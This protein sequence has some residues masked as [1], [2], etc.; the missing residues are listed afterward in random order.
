MAW[1]LEDILDGNVGFFWPQ[2]NYK[3]DISSEPERG[4]IERKDRI[5]E[6]RTLE[7]DPLS[8]FFDM[9]K[10]EKMRKPHAVV[11]STEKTG[12]VLA[13]VTGIGSNLV[14]GAAASVNRFRGQILVCGVDVTTLKSVRFNEIEVFFPGVNRWFGVQPPK[15]SRKIDKR[16][17]LTQMSI[18]LR[19]DK[20]AIIP[21]TDSS[22]LTIYNYWSLN[23]PADS[24]MIFAPVSIGVRSRKRL[25]LIDLLAPIFQTQNLLNVAYR[26]FVSANGGRV[27]PHAMGEHAT[28]YRLWASPV[29]TKPPHASQATSLT[30]VPLF[31]LSQLGGNEA[32]SKWIQLCNDLPRLAGP[33]ANI[34][35]AGTSTIEAQLLT[36]GATIDYW[37]GSNK[38]VKSWAKSENFQPKAVINSLPPGFDYLVGDIDKWAERFWGY[39]NAI[40]HNVSK[41]NIDLAE[42]YVLAQSAHVLVTLLALNEI[43]TRPQVIK[44]ICE[45]HR[46][47]SLRDQIA[48]H[49][50]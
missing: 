23:G 43:S 13:N 48:T 31:S 11:G 8:E 46:L 44:E 36:S 27:R 28:Y 40:K 50:K 39:Y 14:V 41:F 22:K 15:V 24:Q 6:I 30:E 21:L 19:S 7:E 34:Y 4:Y 1:E 17:R 25:E 3:V 5:V 26:G 29:M 32:L 9:N 47:Y 33:A 49:L 45:S 38:K 35:R 37:H 12:V 2:K 20:P 18:E 42:L 16:G 10:S